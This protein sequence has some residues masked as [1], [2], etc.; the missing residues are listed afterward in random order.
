MGKSTHGAN[1]RSVPGGE[2]DT[3]SGE[4]RFELLGTRREVPGASSEVRT[5]RAAVGTGDEYA[6]GSIDPGIRGGD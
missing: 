2:S 5:A 6:L 4:L 1:E 3:Q